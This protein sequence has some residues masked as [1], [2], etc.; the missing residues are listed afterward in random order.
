MSAI[1]VIYAHPLG[2]H[3]IANRVLVDAI[4]DLPSVTVR[5]LYEIYPDY[6]V[7]PAT[8]QP[9]IEAAQLLVLQH[10]V[11]W[12]SVPPLLKQW[13]DTVFHVGWAYGP[14]GTAPWTLSQAGVPVRL[15]ERPRL[16]TPGGHG[17]AQQGLL[18]GRD[19]GRRR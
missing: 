14:G 17:P 6:N 5:D 15:C 9:L 18:V 16:S 1:L 11:Y 10:P 2:R 7:D 13:L 4:R 19:H 3:S 12:Y 8:E